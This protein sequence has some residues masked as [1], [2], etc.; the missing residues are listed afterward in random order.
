MALITQ[1]ISMG[2]RY[3]AAPRSLLILLA[4]FHSTPEAAPSAELWSHWQPSAEIATLKMDHTPWQNYLQRRVKRGSD[5]IARVDYRATTAG[6]KRQIEAYLEQLQQ[7][8]VA[9]LTGAQQRAFWINLYNAGTVAVIL[10]HF[11]V[12]S[13]RDIDISPGLFAD[14]PWGR[15][16]FTIDGQKVSLDDIEH[17]ILRPIWRDNRIHYA[18]N[19]AS[20]GCPDLQTSAFTTDNTERLLNDAA[21]GFI[22]HPRAAHIVDGEL[23]VSSIYKWF[24]SDFGG[25]ETGVIRHLTKYAGAALASELE[26]REEI[27]DYDYDWSLNSVE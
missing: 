7:T 4:L 18:L 15:K 27:D 6:E 24:E 12:T 3:R 16:L 23:V 8:P 22:N 1:G 14:G 2:L 9:S 17:R 20:L 26:G 10:G 13:I 19:C 21:K 11:P 25:S 5:G